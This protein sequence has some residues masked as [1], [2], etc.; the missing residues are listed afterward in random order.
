MKL[1]QPPGLPS[2]GGGLREGSRKQ[3]VSL[4]SNEWV[5][6]RGLVANKLQLSNFGIFF[7]RK[8]ESYFNHPYDQR[9]AFIYPPTPTLR[10]VDHKHSALTPSTHGLNCPAMDKK[11]LWKPVFSVERMFLLLRHLSIFGMH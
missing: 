3:Q 5:R 10:S 6:P 11:L 8:R 7:G 2:E 9:T 4:W 1:P